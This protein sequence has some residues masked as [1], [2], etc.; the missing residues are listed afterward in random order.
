MCL[1]K[2][3]ENETCNEKGNAVGRTLS[4]RYCPSRLSS[5]RHI[6]SSA[7][8]DVVNNLGFS[9][10]LLVG[11]VN[12]KRDFCL[13]L[14]ENL[15]LNLL[16]LNYEGVRIR[17][18]ASKLGHIMGLPDEGS[19]VLLYGSVESIKD[20]N[21]SL[22]SHVR[23]IPL[24]ELVLEIESSEDTGKLFTVMITLLVMYTILAPDFGVVI[25]HW[26]L[27]GAVEASNNCKKNWSKWSFDNLIVG[28]SKFKRIT[29]QQYVYG[30]LLFLQVSH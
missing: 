10:H 13:K 29:G 30:N 17:I 25:P 6:M 18:F 11:E 3:V 14:I 7:Q 5:L 8:V 16:E 21:Q 24:N 28:I 27:H 2:P 23:G 26:F 19:D 4:T 9:S 15:D 22:C 20:F 1:K 12:I